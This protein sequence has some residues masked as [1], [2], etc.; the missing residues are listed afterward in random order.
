MVA[1]AALL[2]LDS[3]KLRDKSAECDIISFTVDGEAWSI[4]DTSISR[5]YPEGMPFFLLLTPSITVSPGATI[6]PAPVASQDF[7]T[8]RGVSYTVTAKDGATTKTYTAKALV[9]KESGVTGECTWTLAGNSDDHYTL[10]ISG[11]GAMADYDI[12]D[13]APWLYCYNKIKA[14]VIE[15]GVTAIGAYAFVICRGLTSVIFP[16]SLTAIGEWAFVECTGLT[17]V[18]IP[19]SVISIGEHAFFNCGSLTSVTNHSAIPQSIGHDTFPSGADT[20]RV[21]AS[22]VEA[23]GR[24]W[25]WLRFGTIEAI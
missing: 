13:Y 12:E 8:D 16:N 10:I 17:S 23:Y 11:N 25:Y 9:T 6:S 24:H 7:F 18:V 15:D 22:A 19:G 4:S 21:P 1:L 2:A 14:L 5:V 20:L 3:C